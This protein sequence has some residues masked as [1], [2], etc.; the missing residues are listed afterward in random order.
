MRIFRGF[1]NRVF[2][3]IMAFAAVISPCFCSMAADVTVRENIE[4][5]PGDG[6]IIIGVEGVDVT[7]D[8]QDLLDTINK[9]RQKACNDG[10]TPDPRDK[11]R[12]LQP[13]DYVPIKIGVNCSKTA[14]IRAAEGSVRL[15][16]TRPNG[17][18]CSN[19]IKYFNSSSGSIAENL[20]W[21]G[22]LSS[23]IK[24]W[25]DERDA[26]LGIK[27]GETG[28]YVSLINPTYQY[29]GM[30][31]FNPVNDSAPYDWS[32][33]AGAYAVNDT[34]LTALA[35]AKNETVI[36]KM[37]IP[38]AN[39][40]SLDIAGD[41]ILH[42]G[43]SVDLRLLVAFEFLE[44]TANAASNTTID[45][46]VYKGVSWSSSDESVISISSDGKVNANAEG[47]VTITAVIGSGTNKQ[48]C[49]RDLLVIPT[50]VDVTEV[51][52]PDTITVE[53]KEK[54]LLSKV[55]KGILSD[56]E[57]VDINVTWD[58][59]DEKQLLTHFKSNEFYIS[60]DAAGFEVRQ[61]VHVNAAELLKAYTDPVSVTTD[62]GVEPDYP[63]VAYYDL[64]NGYTWEASSGGIKWSEESKQYYKTREGGE[65][66]ITGYTAAYFTTDEGQKQLPISSTLIVN[67]ATVKD[68]EFDEDPI[69][70]ISG[71]EPIY[72][73]A[74]VTWSNGDVTDEVITWNR[75]DDFTSAYMRRS[76]GTYIIS[77]TYN[78][79]QTHVTVNVS[80][81]I[82]TAVN[83]DNSDILVDNGTA[84]VLPET[85]E[86]RWSNG[87]VEDTDIVWEKVSKDKYCNRTGGEFDINGTV[88]G[89]A[90]LV[91]CKVA[92]PVIE[93]I[94]ELSAA[95]TVEGVEPKLPEQ[96]SVLWNNG[97]TT[98][99]NILWNDIEEEKYSEPDS[100]FRVFGSIADVSEDDPNNTISIEVNVRA[101]SLTDLFW[102]EIDSEDV[103]DGAEASGK[104]V[105]ADELSNPSGNIFYGSYDW[106][107]IKGVLMACYDNGTS[108][109]IDINDDRLV[110]SGFDATSTESEQQ[111]EVSFTYGKEESAVT[112]TAAFTAVLHLP[113]TIEITKPKK[114]VYIEGQSFDTTGLKVVT[115]YDDGKKIDPSETAD[116]PVYVLQG[117][118]SA[119]T[120]T[121]T[122]TVIQD[123]LSEEF[124][125]IVIPRVAVDI[126]VSAIYPQKVDK[127]LNVE[128]VT[129]SI[130]FN[131]ESVEEYQL[132]ELVEAEKVDITGYDK[133][134]LGQQTIKI[135]YEKVSC[136][137]VIE[138]RDK[139]ITD[140]EITELPRQLNYIEGIE[141]VL[142]G[143]VVKVSYDNDT[144]ENVEMTENMI[145][146]YD[147]DRIG[148]QVIS[149]SIDGKSDTFTVNVRA[150]KV[151]S[152]YVV[153]LDKLSYIEGTELELDGG[154]ICISYDNG[155]EDR[156][157]LQDDD[158][159]V[160]LISAN[161]DSAASDLS[162]LKAGEYILDISY[163]D[164]SL[165]TEEGEDINV[166]VKAPVND[167]KAQA[168][169][170]SKVEF[171]SD[172][173][174][175]TIVASLV[176]TTLYIPCADGS[177]EPVIVT[178]DMIAAVI[179]E[180]VSDT[181]DDAEEYIIKTVKI[182]VGTKTDP[183]YGSDSEDDGIYT[184]LSVKVEKKKTTNSGNV[185]DNQQEENNNQEVVPQDKP[186]GQ[187]DVIQGENASKD[188]DSQNGTGE[189]NENSQNSSQGGTG[190]GNQGSGDDGSTQDTASDGSSNTN[191]KLGKTSISKI[192]SK[193]KAFTVKWKK[194][195]KGSVT[196]YQ[197]QYSLKKNFKK[198]T[199][200]V[201]VSKKSTT[202]KTIKKLK[203]K[204]KYYV[205]IRT[206]Y[207]KG[208][209][210]WYSA[211]SKTKAVKIK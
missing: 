197:I 195:S 202:S 58:S 19:V 30:S 168:A 160:K 175:N 3:L 2:V 186:S 126:A 62:S 101:K 200:T 121:Q 162:K 114:T 189:G 83:F 54:P 1:G 192:T 26:Y 111:V 144:Y 70:T 10:I 25:I 93:M 96:V 190:S 117:Y 35:G 56:G 77:G 15:S 152:R 129:A 89:K 82:V 116:I 182:R 201:T 181:D 172:A 180:D 79:L 166:I 103:S 165:Y 170:S 16:H 4:S 14:V 210:K 134:A 20:A 32:C 34:E 110:I 28:H 51:E 127:D 27:T 120:G 40:T 43:D 94:D 146:G 7:S 154:Y 205:R 88:A 18:S 21:N 184:Y 132:S 23:D 75:T 128:G 84:P 105:N 52:D 87:D 55:V 46:P 188:S 109:E 68:V 42:V 104:G 102:K 72:P 38:V 194:V 133:T 39:V 164:E 107:S 174:D 198:N 22:D 37:E 81:A 177:N 11:S 137:A 158:V 169:D 17:E 149:V 130:I 90:V 209:K 64:S 76:G 45:C 12:M 178:E 155:T 13:D 59:Y 44:S 108:E 176:G 66:T 85:A 8:L 49:T 204:K 138:V 136:E 145:S 199:K 47:K 106:S 211:W 161:D 36:Q 208:S 57:E 31:T 118:K 151:V 179:E 99:E 142:T 143:G 183:E 9:E 95:E 139:I 173:D 69:S 122:I 74:R 163:K 92:S 80:P 53:T 98:V 157:S 196:G 140:M 159:I 206:Y 156:I 207:K 61:R 5:T 100:S 63:S 65:F 50:G 113:Q 60:G 91:T 29:T 112:R 97:L 119:V 193:K 6:K 153:M 33:T 125:I 73:K 147:K 78:D 185:G 171:S 123:G 191:I 187:T 203:S 41:T 135:K 67:P 48:S 148:M 131:D 124:D 71:V 24:G 141:L 115:V 150:K 167:A 86:V